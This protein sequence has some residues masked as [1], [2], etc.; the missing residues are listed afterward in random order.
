[1]SYLWK[2]HS[3]S[4]SQFAL[5]PTGRICAGNGYEKLVAGGEPQILYHEEDVHFVSVDKQ[6][7]FCILIG[8]IK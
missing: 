4:L 2:R 3:G 7:I 6:P 5:L 1:M 8:P